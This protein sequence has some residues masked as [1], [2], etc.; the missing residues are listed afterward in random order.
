[1][2]NRKQIIRLSSIANFCSKLH[3]VPRGEREG[4]K[5][6]YKFGHLTWNDDVGAA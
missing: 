6:F 2:Q 3:H 1:M 4:R 5:D